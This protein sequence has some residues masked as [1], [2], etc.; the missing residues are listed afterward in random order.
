M[1][2]LYIVHEILGKR[3]VYAEFLELNYGFVHIG[4]DSPHRYFNTGG[5]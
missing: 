3:E 2:T 5:M 1:E 4:A